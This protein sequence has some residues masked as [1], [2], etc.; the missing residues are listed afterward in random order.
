VEALS[1][2]NPG[3]FIP[4][5]REVGDTAGGGDRL[6]V[7]GLLEGLQTVPDT[8][9]AAEHDRDLDEMHVVDE[10]G[11]EEVTYDGGAASDT[12]VLAI[13]C[14]AGFLERLGRGGVEEVE[15]GAA[16]HL[17]RGPRAVSEP[18]VGVWKGGFGPHQPFQSGSSR[19][20][21]APRSWAPTSSARP[22]DMDKLWI[23]VSDIRA[24]LDW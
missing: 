10:S 3:R 2:R 21:S 19:Q 12:D 8:D 4:R 22:V 9:A 6:D 14:F 17:D 18:K 16:L 20:A 1:P 24:L 13:G 11:G 23:R 7:V 15:R 5:E